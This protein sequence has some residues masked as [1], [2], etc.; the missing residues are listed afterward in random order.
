MAITQAGKSREK[1]ADLEDPQLRQ[2]PKMPPAGTD[3]LFQRPE[4]L[5][6]AV[7]RD[8]DTGGVPPCASA[9]ASPFTAAHGPS[10]RKPSMAPG[11]GKSADLCAV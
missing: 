8:C 6:H 11:V 9:L 1:P 3:K 7:R 2:S 5:R 4:A 10:Q